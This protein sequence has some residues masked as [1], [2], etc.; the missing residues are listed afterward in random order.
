MHKLQ[1]ILDVTLLTERGAYAI[2]K[3]SLI[4]IKIYKK[5][6][7]FKNISSDRDFDRNSMAS[8]LLSM[9]YTSGTRTFCNL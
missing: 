5:L 2:L 6:E 4:K 9:A 3:V 1:L 8:R 7:T